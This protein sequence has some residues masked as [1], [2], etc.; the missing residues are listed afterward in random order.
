MI[1]DEPLEILR[2]L[3]GKTL[4]DSRKDMRTIVGRGKH[5]KCISI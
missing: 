4:V 5:S 2:D 3:P 1:H